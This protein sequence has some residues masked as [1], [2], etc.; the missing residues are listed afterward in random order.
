MTREPLPFLPFGELSTHMI[1]DIKMFSSSVAKVVPSLQGFDIARGKYFAGKN[2]VLNINGFKIAATS[3]SP[4]FI[5]STEFKETNLMFPFQGGCT[6]TLENRSYT[7]AANQ[8]AI[9]MPNTGRSSLS[10]D[11]RSGLVMDLDENRLKHV[12]K[13][14]LG[15][16]RDTQIDLRLHQPRLIPLRSGDISFDLAMRQLCGIIDSYNC[17]QDILEKLNVDE[18]FYRNIIM[19]LIPDMFKLG[20]KNEVKNSVSQNT[21]KLILDYAKS[22]PN[23]F[24][25]LMDLEE[26]SGLSSRSLQYAFKNILNTTPTQWLRKHRLCHARD[27]I[28]NHR[29]NVSRAAVNSGFVNFSFFSKYYKEEFGELPSD[30]VRNVR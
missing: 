17:D 22:T 30:T 20:H 8:N 25:T 3:C 21:I 1:G 11:F 27:L 2:I 13:I 5:K 10:F 18:M 6:A 12:A 28:I 29:M 4:T 14:M 9:L 7:W 16:S 26:F 19:M 23:A 15:L 24:S